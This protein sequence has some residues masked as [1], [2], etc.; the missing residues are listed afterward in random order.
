[1][2]GLDG[3]G[4]AP[5]CRADFVLLQ[6]RSPVEAIR[7]RAHRLLVVRRGKVIA[8]LAGA[9]SGARPARPAGRRVDWTLRRRGLSGAA[10]DPAIRGPWP[11]DLLR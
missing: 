10:G 5:G 7:L 3:Y 11:E 6:A 9:A 8:A 4:L 1:M 2:L